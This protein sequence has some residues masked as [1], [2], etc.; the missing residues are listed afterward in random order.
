MVLRLLWEARI[1]KEGVRAE[2]ILQLPRSMMSAFD[3]LRSSRGDFDRREF[4]LSDRFND[5]CVFTPTYNR[6]YCLDKLFASLCDQTA[7]NFNWLIVDDGSTDDT[8]ALVEDFKKVSPFPITYL[9]QANGG[10]QRAHNVA[11]EHCSSELFFCVDS[12]D[13]LVCDA[14]ASIWETWDDVRSSSDYAGV[15]ALQGPGENTPHYGRM[16]K[17]LRTTTMWDLYYKH[18]HR[19]DTAHIYKTSVLR[20]YPF[21]VEDGEK[22]IAET[23]VYHQI[24]QR[25]K[26]AVLDKV[27][28]IQ[29]YLSDGYSK[30]VRQVTR[31]NPKG[32]RKLKRMYILYADTP[33]AY[34]ESTILYMVGCLLCGDTKGGIKDAPNKVGAVLALLPAWILT[35]TEFRER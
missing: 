22:F 12:D 6:A 21:E 5:I 34:I 25:Y 8:E 23:Y 3:N 20:D 15:I 18:G 19:G 29:E 13:Q 35:K 1:W 7:E 24:D 28:T 2:V 30:N 16:P 32:Y 10:K 11:V 9:K 33:R 17:G 4:A 31:S 14:L 27:V 26:L